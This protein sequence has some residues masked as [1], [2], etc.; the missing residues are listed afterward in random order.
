MGSDYL[1][2]PPRSTPYL[3]PYH[4]GRREESQLATTGKGGT[5]ATLTIPDVAEALGISTNTA[6][7]W[8]RRRRIPGHKVGRRW[9]V[10]REVFDEWRRTGE[11]N[12]FLRSVGRGSDDTLPPARTH[13]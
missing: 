10:D 13:T 7:D 11:R 1:W 9:I 12:P 4:E 6:Y 5:R 2:V 3:S 8:I